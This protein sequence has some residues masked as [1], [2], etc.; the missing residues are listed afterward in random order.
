MKEIE[1]LE[2][3]HSDLAN[4]KRRKLSVNSL[5][6]NVRNSNYDIASSSQFQSKVGDAVVHNVITGSQESLHDSNSK[7]SYDDKTAKEQPSPNT[8][9]DTINNDQLIT[10][11]GTV[12]LEKD[13]G[14]QV[15]SLNNSTDNL[16][17]KGIDSTVEFS[18]DRDASKTLPALHSS[19]SGQGLDSLGRIVGSHEGKGTPE[20]LV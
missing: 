17:V 19:S 8:N 3:E 1:R 16:S 18:S 4:K 7:V 15:P 10:V 6:D 14:C 5:I 9:L 11:R 12:V 20:Y 13:K 2:E